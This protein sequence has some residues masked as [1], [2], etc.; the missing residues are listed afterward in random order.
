MKR[1]IIENEIIWKMNLKNKD[2]KTYDVNEK[3]CSIIIIDCLKKY[4]C[5]NL[6]RP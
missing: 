5:K 2:L 4:I 3:S 6:L 1:I